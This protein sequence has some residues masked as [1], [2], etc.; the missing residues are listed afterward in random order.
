MSEKTKHGISGSTLKII[1]VISMLIDH[2]AAAVIVR[3]I[4]A[5][6]AQMFATGTWIM[7]RYN[8]SSLFT[9]YYAMRNI[10]RI[11]FP[12]Y[13]FLLVEGFQR[14]RNEM[15]YAARLAA[16][17]LVSEIPFDLAFNSTIYAFEY[18]NVFFTLLLGLLAMIEMDTVGKHQWSE[19]Q[20]VQRTV[21]GL[22]DAGGILICAKTADFLNTDY[23]SIG[24]LCIIALYLLRKWKLP[25]AIVGALSFSWE[26]PASLAFAPIYF[27]N[28]KRG[29]KMKYFFYVFYPLHLLI[30]YL[31]CKT[32]GIHVFAAI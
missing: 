31:I 23:H 29:L 3:L 20:F 22:L 18:Q 15:K 24:V 9:A 21:V 16:F 12:I 4:Y 5:C 8:D 13:C 26:F 11:A 2:A 17:A 6:N 14:T 32:L 10:G 7:D 28:G 19:K 27:Y 1:A 25:Q 30:L